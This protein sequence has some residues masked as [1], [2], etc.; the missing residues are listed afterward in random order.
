[1]VP[2][3]GLCLG[4][5]ARE[6]HVS[7]RLPPDICI[8]KNAY[9]THQLESAIDTYDQHRNARHRTPDAG[10]KY[11]KDYG[12]AEFYGWSEDKARQMSRAERTGVGK[13][14]RDSGF[15]LS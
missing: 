4:Y 13:F 2:L 10:Q 15:S 11:V 7:M 1:M 12:V 14:A 9:S 5:P 3:A 8:H 6:G